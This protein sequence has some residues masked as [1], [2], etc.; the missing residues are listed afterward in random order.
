MRGAIA[1]VVIA[2]GGVVAVAGQGASP[3]SALQQAQVELHTLRVENAQ[4]RAR[5]ADAQATVDSLRLS[6]ERAALEQQLRAELAPP[7]GYVFDW[8]ARRF[9][10][11]PPQ[12][13]K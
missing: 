4:L 12:E 9:V 6:A 2:L 7:E 1:C 13:G 8:P 11:P 5:L 10:P 3:L